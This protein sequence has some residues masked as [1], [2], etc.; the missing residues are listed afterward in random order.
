MKQLNIINIHCGVKIKEFRKKSGLSQDELAGALS[1][2]RTSVC[3][4]ESG[5]QGLTMKTFLWLVPY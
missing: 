3:N 5:K 1:L 4:L 2:T